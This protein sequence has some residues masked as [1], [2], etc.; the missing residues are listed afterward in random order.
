MVLQKVWNIRLYVL[1]V[2][3]LN[4]GIIGEAL[5]VGILILMFEGKM[6]GETKELCDQASHQRSHLVAY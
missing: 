2:K 4:Y 5:L 1:F 3:V 6:G